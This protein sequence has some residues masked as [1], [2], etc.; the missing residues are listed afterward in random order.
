[1]SHLDLQNVFL[2]VQKEG[3]YIYTI[4]IHLRNHQRTCRLSG[5]EDFGEQ[6]NFDD[7]QALLQ[8]LESHKSPIE[9]EPAVLNVVAGGCILDWGFQI[10]SR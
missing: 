7:G 5:R 10:G 4:S 3:P 1:M 2:M 9:R 6:V 8:P